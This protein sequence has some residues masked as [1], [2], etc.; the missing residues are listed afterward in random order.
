MI[1][2]TENIFPSVHL[3]YKKGD[4]IV[5]EGDYGVSIYKIISGTVKVFTES[6]GEA[7]SLGYEL[8]LNQLVLHSQDGF[9]FVFH[10]TAGDHLP[11]S[12]P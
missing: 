4:L 12:Q 5:K 3:K 1:S 2:Q 11:V 10:R 8:R 6:Q 9:M 7:T